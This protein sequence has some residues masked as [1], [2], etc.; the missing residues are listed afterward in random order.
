[1]DTRDCVGDLVSNQAMRKDRQVSLP[2]R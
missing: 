2:L 1:V